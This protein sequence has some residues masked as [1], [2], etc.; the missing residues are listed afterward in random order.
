M[1]AFKIPWTNEIPY[2]NPPFKR[3]D[4]CLFKL[5][6]D[7]VPEALIVVPYWKQATWFKQ[8]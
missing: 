5:I 3:I 4:D 8:L 2:L 6:H 1:D 7:E